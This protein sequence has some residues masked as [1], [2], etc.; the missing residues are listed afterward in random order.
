ML[1][2]SYAFLFGFL[3]A[4]LAGFYALNVYSRPLAVCWLTAASLFF[5]AYWNSAYVWLVLVS[6][7]FNY[8]AGR[9]ILLLREERPAAARAVMGASVVCNLLLL[10]YYKYSGFFVANVTALWRDLRGCR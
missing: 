1:F 7:V 8:G 10:G 6:I 3:P 2:N 4:A 9:A 5:Y